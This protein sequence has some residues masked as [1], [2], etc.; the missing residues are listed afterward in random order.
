M[1]WK[2]CVKRK[3]RTHDGLQCQSDTKR[4]NVNIWAGNQSFAA[5]IPETVAHWIVSSHSSILEQLTEG[6]GT[7]ETLQIHKGKWHKSCRNT[8]SDQE[9]KK[10]YWWSWR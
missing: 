2:Q 5:S 9:K 7:A 3:D 1:D 10:T 4:T 8:F 6:Y